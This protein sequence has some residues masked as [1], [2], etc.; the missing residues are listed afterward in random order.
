MT[1]DVRK[2]RDCLIYAAVES[3][4]P[5]LAVAQVFAVSQTTIYDALRKADVAKP[6]KEDN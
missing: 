1:K 6:P 3:G 4:A 2:L 5:I